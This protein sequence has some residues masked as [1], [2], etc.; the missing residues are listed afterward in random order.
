MWHGWQLLLVANLLYSS[1]LLWLTV[2]LTWSACV[3]CQLP[4]GLF[5]III[6]VELIYFSW[7]RLYGAILLLMALCS[8]NALCRI[9]EVT[10]RRARLVLGWVTVYE[11]VKPASQPARTTQPSTLCGRVN[12]VYIYQEN[13]E[14]FRP[15]WYIGR[16]A[17]DFTFWLIDCW[18]DCLL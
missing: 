18:I 6:V 8:G 16:S 9:N 12:W 1:M 15:R 5:S 10:L 4:F 17:S 2:R 14:K 11:Q 3:L 13:A 7:C